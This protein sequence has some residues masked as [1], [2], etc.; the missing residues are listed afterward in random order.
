[1]RYHRGMGTRTAG[2][3]GVACLLVAG[4]GT[5]SMVRP[6]RTLPKGQVELA[7]GLAASNLGEVNTIL[8]GAVGL[9]DRVELLGQNE[10]W[11][12]FVELRYAILKDEPAHGDAVGL[13]VGA[14]AGQ[15]V[16]LVSA[17]TE[18]GEEE[19]NE[20]IDG[21][22]GLVS[23]SVGKTWG[24]TTLTLAHRTFFLQGGYAA[25][26]TRLALRL[27]VSGGF[28]FFAETGGT[29]HSVLSEPAVGLVL[30][31]AAL[32]FWVGF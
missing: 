14:G 13:V 11:N 31:E 25:S 32:G 1:M 7:A 16:T 12:S 19:S 21:A 20:S 23:A 27:A 8:H 10:I 6:A 22:A 9:G 3:L 18:A 24:N 29:A 28:G 4:C 5:Y 17:V 30:A 26:S 2:L 15:A